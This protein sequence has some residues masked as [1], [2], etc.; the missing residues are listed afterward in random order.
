[1]K[2]IGK[3]GKALEMGKEAAN[4]ERQIRRLRE[5]DGMIEQINFEL[6]FCVCV[7]LANQFQVNGM[8]KEALNTYTLIVKNRNY[9]NSGRLRVNMGNIY[10]SQKNYPLCIKMY[11]MALDTIP[12]V[13][14]DMRIKIIKNIGHA[15]VRLGE[16][17]DAIDSYE[18]IM[19]SE[20]DFQTGFNLI[21][22]YFA[23]GD[24]DR[25]KKWY[26][27]MLSIELPGGEEFDEDA[28]YDT[29]DDQAKADPLKEYLKSEREKALGYIVKASKLIAPEIDKDIINGY[30]WVLE[31]LKQASDYPTIES[32]IE[33]AKAIHFIKRKEFD[34]AIEVFKSFEK[35]D[36]VM[37]AIA[38]NNISFLYFLE[39]DYDQAE[40]FAQVATEHDRYNAKALVNKGNCFFIKGELENAK[41]HYLEAIGVE[42][43]C[44]EAIF[45]LGLVNK[46]MELWEDTLQAFDKLQ[47]IIP[48][49]PEVMY[50]LGHIHEIVGNYKAAI[51]W[52]QIL[53][54]RIPTDPNILL[55]IGALYYKEDDE[56]QAL[57]FHQESYRY[58]PANI[59]TISWLGIYYAKSD[60]YEKGIQF[61]ERASQIQPA[62]VKWKLMVA[63][64]YRKMNS[65]QEAL[66]LY[67]EINEQHPDNLEC[68]YII[69]IYNIY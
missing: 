29:K 5:Q 16:Y 35:K 2:S 43:N 62:E 51:K 7:N 25:M 61:F 17:Q 54:T 24:H 40:K 38:A 59:D 6:T 52:Y 26:T 36:Q 56:I 15:F 18:N 28:L 9:P 10:F 42:A 66:R 13:N 27:K 63:T 41:E 69:Y 64:C 48:R 20:P 32:E 45:N 11:R 46:R 8:F 58:Y 19:E 33:M 39:R 34:N 14:K 50:Q 22:C 37:M 65:Y 1:M 23:L 49:N 44:I 30:N 68:I 21:V 31:T 3:F 47:T 53:I 57:H 12:S 55:R 60:L 67:Q 4:K